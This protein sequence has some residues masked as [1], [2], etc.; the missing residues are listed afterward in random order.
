MTNT[1]VSRCKRNRL[2]IA[3]LSALTLPMMAPA[4]AQEATGEAPDTDSRTLDK[5]VVTGSLIPQ[6]QLET[7]SPVMTI[8][9]EDI[10][11]RGFTSVADVLQRYHAARNK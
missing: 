3:L 10:R 2:S 9:A 11:S 4:L 8:S 1:P 7:F 5:V 6:T